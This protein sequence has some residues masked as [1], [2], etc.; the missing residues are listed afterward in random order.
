MI[1]ENI[2]KV[3]EWLGC[4]CINYCNQDIKGVDKDSRTIKEGMLYVPL[5]GENFDGHS[6]VNSVIEDGVTVTL[7]DKNH[8]PYPN[9]ITCLLVDDVLAAVQRLAKKYIENIGAKIVAIT[10]SNG[11]TSIK[12][13]A[14]SVLKVKYKVSKTLLNYNNDIGLPLSVLNAYKDDEY[15]VLEMGM[16]NIGDISRLTDIAKP[17]Y[18]IISNIGSAHL[19]N[20]KTRSN[21]AKAK[22]EIIQNM[23]PTG[24]FIKNGMEP[25]LDV[26]HENTL[27]FGNTPMYDIYP[28][29]I[30]LDITGLYFDTNILKNIYIK[31]F[32]IAQVENAMSVI[33]LAKN[34]GLTD[35]EIL[36]GLREVE[37]TG[38]RNNIY[39][40]KTNY[41][42]DD[43]YKSNPEGLCKALETMSYFNR[44]KIAV[45]S[46]MKE[47]GEG[48]IDFHMQVGEKLSEYNIDKVYLYGELSRYTLGICLERN[49]DVS[50]YQNKFDM[51]PDLKMEKNSIILFKASNSMKIFEVIEALKN[52]E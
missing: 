33:L 45:I 44:R 29:N 39:E 52:E 26:E 22:L 25:L 30:R 11:K 4:E 2:D 5:K 12:D 32:G 38:K 15:L 9:N 14:Y 36:Q 34:I 28:S 47:L 42:Y 37:F 51:I 31:T 10:G 19:E 6:F 35:E 23:D 20:L 13:M 50:Y 27:T 16:D 8:R 40:F 1:I 41:I 3:I 24:L 48:E 17:D 46:D 7:W 18:A 49:I 21:I 43:S